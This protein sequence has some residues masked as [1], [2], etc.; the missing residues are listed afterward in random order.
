M[1]IFKLVAFMALVTLFS[2]SKVTDKC[3]IKGQL[4]GGNGELVVYPYQEVHSKQESDSLTYKATIKDGKF[5]LEMDSEKASR[6]MHIKI[7]KDYKSYTLFS[8]PGVIKITE[9]KGEL[10]AEGSAT[11]DEYQQ[12]LEKLNYKAYDNLKYKKML[13]SEEQELVDQYNSKL[14]EL[15]KEYSNSVP[16]SQLFYEKYWGADVETLNKIINSF[17]KEIQD[18]YYIKR[19]IERKANQQRVS[20]GK[21][22]PDF[23]LKSDKS[24]VISLSKYK[25]KYLLVDFWASWCRPCRAE[26]PNVKKIYE[27]YKAKGLE[28]L[29]VSTDTD[30]KAWL[31]A[32]DQEQMPWAQVR[33]TKSVSK[34]YNITYIPMIFLMDSN[35]KI[36]DKGLHGEGLRKRVEELFK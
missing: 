6:R 18:S 4:S 26:I 35:G 5:E 27:D 23:S 8:E 21:Q 17:S 15:T 28:V 1:K 16:L 12:L 14:W 36:I 29:S 9:T 30:E 34:A 11:N 19:M 33:D 22:A 7:G 25:G 10:V 31:K 32:V 20:I 13:S 24:E 3:I 2:C